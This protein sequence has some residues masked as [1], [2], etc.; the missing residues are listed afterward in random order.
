MTG[1]SVPA[2]MLT[3]WRIVLGGWLL[4]WFINTPTNLLLFWRGGDYP[5]TEHPLI[6][7]LFRAPWLAQISLMLP[8]LGV[9]GFV[10]AHPRVLQALAALLCLC[11]LLLLGH[12]FSYNDA[13]YTTAF[14]TS[15]WLIWF[16]SRL[17]VPTPAARAGT[18]CHGI[19]IGQ[20]MIGL[21]FFGGFIGKLTPEYWSG[22][23]LDHIYM[24]QKPTLLFRFLRDHWSPQTMQVW[25]VWLAQL[26]VVA[27]GLMA[28]LIV[29]PTRFAAIGTGCVFS[30]MILLAGPQIISVL[31]S[32]AGLMAA[33]LY[34]S[35][36]DAANV[37]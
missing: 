36:S 32:L 18:V 6:P 14:W 31:G 3:A 27:E 7:Q 8:L 28:T 29:W 22:E 20:G 37:R 34:L 30:F 15:L 24:I 19:A 16:A 35:E 10:C 5:I 11:A 33:C 4:A 2:T 13:T 12:I 17:D 23:A 9:A 26:M 21:C 1:A 25:A